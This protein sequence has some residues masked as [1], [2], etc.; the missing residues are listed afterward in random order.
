MNQKVTLLVGKP[1]LFLQIKHC[2]DIRDTFKVFTPITVDY[3]IAKDVKVFT[4]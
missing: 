1:R 2:L 4:I 3:G